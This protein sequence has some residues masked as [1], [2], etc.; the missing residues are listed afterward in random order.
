MR[1][2]AQAPSDPL[3]S[4]GTLHL[5]LTADFEMLTVGTNGRVQRLQGTRALFF[6]DFETGDLSKWSSVFP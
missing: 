3:R 1:A 5:P 6:D 2:G 4:A